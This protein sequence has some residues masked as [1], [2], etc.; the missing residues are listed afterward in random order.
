MSAAAVARGGIQA[1]FGKCNEE[2]MTQGAFCA[3]SCGRAPCP[4]TEDTIRWYANEYAKSGGKMDPSSGSPPP[5]SNGGGSNSASSGG[6]QGED[7]ISMPNK[8]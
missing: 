4:P 2:W 3:R 6:K 1:A 5:P 8:K 7:F